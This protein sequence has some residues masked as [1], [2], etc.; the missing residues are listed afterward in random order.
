MLMI[1]RGSCGEDYG[2]VVGVLGGTPGSV[3]PGGICGSDVSPPL[4]GP[5][6]PPGPSC[7]AGSAALAGCVAAPGTRTPGPAGR[8]PTRFA[9]RFRLIAST[10]NTPKTTLVAQVSTSPVLEPKAVLPPPPPN[11]LA[12][13]PPRPFWINTSRM[14]IRQT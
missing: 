8:G 5:V 12:N 13:P 2:A 11:A 10:R 7:S 1:M 4:D 3:A 6:G 14:R 9:S